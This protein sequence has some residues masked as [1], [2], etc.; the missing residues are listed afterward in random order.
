[1]VLP[2]GHACCSAI[3]LYDPNSHTGPP[4]ASGRVSQTSSA[5]PAR[6]EISRD[7]GTACL[8]VQQSLFLF[9]D[10]PEQDGTVWGKPAHSAGFYF[11]PWLGSTWSGWRTVRQLSLPRPSPVVHGYP[12]ALGTASEQVV[13]LNDRVIETKQ[14]PDLSNASTRLVK[15]SSERVNRSPL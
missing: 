4:D 2:F 6:R 8:R 11:H 9:G 3:L 10:P 7:A 14:V 5:E 15:S 13:V 1:M 12:H